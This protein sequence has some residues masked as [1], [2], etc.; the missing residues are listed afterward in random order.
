VAGEE[1]APDNHRAVLTFRDVAMTFP[2]TTKPVRALAGVTFAME[3]GEFV[4]IVGPSGCGKSTLLAIAAGLRVPSSGD[5]TVAGE[6]VVGR[7]GKVS[8]MPQRDLL[9]PWLRALDNA[10]L[11]LELAGIP[12]PEARAR[13]AETFAHF[14]LNGFEEHW[15]AQLSGGMRQRVALLRTFLIGHPTV[16]LDEPFG[17]LDALTRAQLHLWVQEVWHPRQGSIL[18]VTHDVDEALFL[19]D[20]VLVMSSRPGTIVRE[21]T[22][23][24]D[25]PR[26]VALFADERFARLKADLLEALER[27][28]AGAPRS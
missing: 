19:S 9:L 4:A 18:L 7:P 20:R 14:G 2:G 6:S 28:G 21:V 22:C 8:F 1:R 27:E 23:P 13:A 15:P 5:V 24:F 25:R 10:A 12:R 11:P 17:A 3:R 26:R 16:L